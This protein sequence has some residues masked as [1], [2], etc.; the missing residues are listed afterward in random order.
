MAVNE[1]LHGQCIAVH[2]QAADATF[3][4]RR[5]KRCFA[6]IFP[7]Q[8][9][10]DMHFYDGDTYSTYGI[11]QGY[12]G[13]GVA[14]GVQDYARYPTHA[15]VQVV[16]QLAFHIALVVADLHPRKTSPQHSQVLFEC[17]A[18]VYMRLPCSQ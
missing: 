1:I 9:V 10:R 15:T 2:A 13:M 8:H 12:A 3:T 5:Y 14:T 4:L 11:G 17:L 16:D 18:A 7:A 6:V